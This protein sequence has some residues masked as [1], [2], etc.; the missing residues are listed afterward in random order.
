LY[1]RHT[2][3][4]RK[5]FLEASGEVELKRDRLRSKE[6]RNTGIKLAK[7]FAQAVSESVESKFR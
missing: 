7:D 2:V 1:H 4:A 6:S 5:N 3:N